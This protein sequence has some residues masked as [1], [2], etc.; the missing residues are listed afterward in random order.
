VVTG[1][2]Y[3]EGPQVD[4]ST[5][6]PN[7]CDHCGIKTR[8]TKTVIV[9]RDGER[10]QVGCAEDILP[11]LLDLSGIKP[12]ALSHLPFSGVSLCP[13]L[14]EAALTFERL[15]VFRMAIAGAGAP[16]D[17]AD[18]TQRKHEAYHLT[19][20][21]PRFKYHALPGGARALYDLDSDPGE[22]M[23]V[24]SKLPDIAARMA[25][26][27]RERWEAV[28]ASGRAFASPPEASPAKTKRVRP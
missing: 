18:V 19:L 26:Q 4:R 2:P 11:T 12:E 8:R 27:C 17:T 21:G 6:S 22:T 23:D 7:A 15:D 5:L 9:E 3:Y 24:Q 14:S 25:K 13:S 16:R 10:K 28:I 20:R 1:S